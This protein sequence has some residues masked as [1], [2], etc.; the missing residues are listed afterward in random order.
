[1][2]LTCLWVSFSPCSP[3]ASFLRSFENSA[4]GKE[5]T[6]A[7]NGRGPLEVE[8]GS[9]G[10]SGSRKPSCDGRKGQQREWE[11]E[12]CEFRDKVPNSPADSVSGEWVPHFPPSPL[13]ACRALRVPYSVW[14]CHLA[15]GQWQRKSSRIQMQIRAVGVGP[16]RI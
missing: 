5:R 7:P 12:G 11:R 9:I 16:G 15:G 1:M 6:A 2:F 13:G 3:P 14:P 8:T 10:Q 4:P